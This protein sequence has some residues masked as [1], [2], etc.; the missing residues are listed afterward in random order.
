MG[1]SNDLSQFPHTTPNN[2][3]PRLGDLV[4]G[5]DG[6]FAV[7]HVGPL[8]CTGLLVYT[9]GSSIVD[10]P[11]DEYAES[12]QHRILVK[13]SINEMEPQNRVQ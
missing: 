2:E 9:D 11:L 10:V 8:A 13:E 4:Y 6:L 3:P 12:F 5:D 1:K 7:C